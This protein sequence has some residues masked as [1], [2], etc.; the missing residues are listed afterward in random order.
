MSKVRLVGLRRDLEQVIDVLYQ[1]GVIQFD[2]PSAEDLNLD[3]GEPYPV[4]DEL[5]E[6]LLKSRSILSQLPSGSSKKDQDEVAT[7]DL[8]EIQ[9]AVENDLADLEQIEE[10]LES[11][12]KLLTTLE[13]IEKTV[14]SLDLIRDYQSLTVYCGTTRN[15]SFRQK[16]KEDSYQL[17]TSSDPDSDFFVLFVAKNKAQEAS[18]LLRSSG[19]EQTRINY[20][21]DKDSFK[22]AKKELKGVIKDLKR[23]KESIRQNLE[24]YSAQWSSYLQE[25]ESEYSEKL[26]KAEAPMHFLT[27][28]QSFLAEGWLPTNDK[29]KV[30][31]RLKEITDSNIHLEEIEGDE[32]DAPIQYNH[33]ESIQP[34]EKLLD[35]YSPPK[36]TEVDP[37]LII[38][39]TFPLFY[40]MMLSDFGYG[41]ITLL[42]FSLLKLKLDNYQH[43][44]QLMIY[45]SIS[46][47]IFGFL[48]GTAFGV[49]FLGSGSALSYQ[50]LQQIPV[51]LRFQKDVMSIMLLSVMMGL[52]QLNLGFIVGF[53]NK[54]VQ[55]GLKQGVTQKLSWI[56]LEAGIVLAAGSQLGW[57]NLPLELGIAI[58][59]IGFILYMW[60]EGPLGI[61]NLVLSIA[62][63]LSYVRLTALGIATVSIATVINLL[64]GMMFDMGLIGILGGIL[65]L[66][67]G[68]LFNVAFQVL[69]SAL[70][71]L[72]LNYVEFFDK[73]YQGGGEK[74]QPFGL[75]KR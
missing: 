33:P 34:F 42:T 7:K 2:S 10:Q 23:E 64:A 11:H 57:V 26:T 17:Y 67:V 38:S 65:I 47:L 39:L 62:D 61:L 59:G 32:D 60:G 68:H 13:D 5:S 63:I 41:L 4:A 72:R 71:S 45:S 18:K 27:S 43:M 3:S 73:F 14:P 22:Q 30:F 46:A 37:T 52:A 54:Y 40:G 58:G 75:N 35:M 16:L 31:Q 56:I 1:L 66:V 9:A 70:H 36:Y 8:E 24:E 44:L 21:K 15:F 55:E 48:S 29:Q 50:F 74:Y 53:Y 19:F 49:T 51:L 20:F 12:R 25:T 28:D 69:G 6:L